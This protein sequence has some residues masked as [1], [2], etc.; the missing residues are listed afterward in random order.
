MDDQGDL[1]FSPRDKVRLVRD[2]KDLRHVEI[3][4]AGETGVLGQRYRVDQGIEIWQMFL[5]TKRAFGDKPITVSIAVA[6]TDLEK[7]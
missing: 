5:D 3:F 6:H 4:K 7:L 1:M 2:C